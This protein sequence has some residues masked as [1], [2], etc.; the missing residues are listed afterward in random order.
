[1]LRLRHRALQELA[2]AFRVCAI[3]RASRAFITMT[4]CVPSSLV[5]VTSMNP[6]PFTRRGYPLADG[7]RT[8]LPSMHPSGG[9]Q[10]CESRT[11]HCSPI[12]LQPRTHRRGAYADIR[13]RGWYQ[14][15]Q[16]RYRADHWGG[17][18]CLTIDADKQ[19]KFR[20]KE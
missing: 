20:L 7:S 14:W 15:F 16:T 5:M 1:M 10:R 8:V 6:Y 19:G 17:Q 2:A 3:D 13:P 9:K 12:G 18:S 11:Y 4:K